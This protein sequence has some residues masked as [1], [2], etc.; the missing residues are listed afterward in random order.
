MA[1]K[2]MMGMHGMG[3]GGSS[4]PSSSSESNDDE[5]G[6]ALIVTVAK[7][8]PKGPVKKAK[9][10]MVKGK[11]VEGGMKSYSKIARPQRFSGLF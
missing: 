2:P 9:G 10:G 1:K 4:G 7:G 8:K 3:N 5:G 11:G 6:M